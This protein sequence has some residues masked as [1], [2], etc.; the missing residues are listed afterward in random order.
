MMIVQVF[1]YFYR[2]VYTV[3]FITAGFWPLTYGSGFYTRNKVLLATW[4]VACFSMSSFTMLPAIKVE[5]TTT[6]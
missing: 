6:M 3:C 2:Q 1:S 4:M 5:N